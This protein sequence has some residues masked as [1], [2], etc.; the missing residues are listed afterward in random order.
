M[1]PMDFTEL[2]AV[3]SCRRGAPQNL[4]LGLGLHSG[5]AEDFTKAVCGLEAPQLQLK[6]PTNNHERCRST[7]PDLHGCLAAG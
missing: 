2:I 4:L 3:C 1:A 6:A 5:D 7:H